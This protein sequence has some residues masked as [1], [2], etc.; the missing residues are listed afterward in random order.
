MA[1]H[2]PAPRRASYKKKPKALAWPHPLTRSTIHPDLLTLHGFHHTPT[3]AQPALTTCFLCEVV[4][5]W[6]EGD[7]PSSVHLDKAPECGWAVLRSESWEK[8]KG[9]TGEARGKDWDWESTSALPWPRQE[10]SFPG[11]ERLARAR[12]MT[13]SAGWPAGKGVPTSEEIAKAGWY[14]RP[15]NEEDE[16]DRCVCA[17]CERAVEGWEKGDDPL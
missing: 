11:N 1:L 7:D 8:D 10:E 4:V 13:F 6:S 5:E 2:L 9:A 15:G 16:G 3:I 12:E 14:F 17:Y